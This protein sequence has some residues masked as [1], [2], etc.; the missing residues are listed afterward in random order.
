MDPFDPGGGLRLCAQIGDTSEFDDPEFGFELDSASVGCD[1]GNYLSL[2]IPKRS[3]GEKRDRDASD[4][5]E[6][7]Q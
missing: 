1:Q 4:E 5:Y 6:I 2:V 7:P 3:G